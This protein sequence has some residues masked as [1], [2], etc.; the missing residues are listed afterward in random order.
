[1]GAGNLS[2]S[3]Q[4]LFV[5]VSYTR[6]QTGSIGVTRTVRRLVEEFQQ[7]SVQ[8]GIT[9]QPVAT[10]SR[11]FRETC[12]ET[13]VVAA[14]TSRDDSGVS[15]RLLR[16]I[17]ASGIRRLALACLPV[18][19]LRWCWRIYSRW[20]FDALSRDATPAVFRPGDFLFMGDAAWHYESSPAIDRARKQGCKVVLMVHDLIPL[21]HPEFCSPLVTNIFDVWLRGVL[22]LADMVICNSRATEDDLKAFSVETGLALPPTGHFRLG[23]DPVRRLDHQP[24]RAELTRFMGLPGPC[25]ATVGSFEPR[26]NYAWLF[27]VFEDLWSDGHDVRLLIAGRPTSD[28]QALVDRI[29]RHPEQGRRLLPLFDADDGELR[30]VYGHARALIFPSLAEGFGL[31]LVEARAYD[32]QVIASDIPAF[33]ELEEPGISYFSVGAADQ[34]SR[35]IVHHADECNSPPHRTSKPAW[36]WAQSSTELLQKIEDLLGQPF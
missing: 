20:T 16:W 21:R 17:T 24:V 36:S 33:R 35:L 4:R 12:L 22:P 25:F 9:C 32:C 13:P 7:A 34:L 11:G 14:T 30:Y 31:P 1:M 8:T 6:T 29:K 26:K 27:E 5:D 23:C 28:G 3:I 19:F 15:A 2:A 10:H 18:S